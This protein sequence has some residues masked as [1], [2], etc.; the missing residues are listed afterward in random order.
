[1]GEQESAIIESGRKWMAGEVSTD[2]YVSGVLQSSARVLRPTHHGQELL[3][4]VKAGITTVLHSLHLH[5][6]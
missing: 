1:M 6:P 5:R 3:R 4:R 2:V